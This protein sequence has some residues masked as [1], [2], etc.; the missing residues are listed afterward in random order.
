MRGSLPMRIA[1]AASGKRIELDT[2]EIKGSCA[3]V[4]WTD[5]MPK[6]RTGTLVKLP[7]EWERFDELR[8]SPLYTTHQL[9]ALTN[10]YPIKAAEHAPKTQRMRRSGSVPCTGIDPVRLERWGEA[11]TSYGCPRDG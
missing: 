2:A 8:Q 3:T 1:R 9:L 7:R 4:S 6:H 10:K 11:V 5:G